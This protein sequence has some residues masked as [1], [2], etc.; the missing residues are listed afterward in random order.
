MGKTFE[1]CNE[2][3]SFNDDIIDIRREFYELS[4]Q[5]E[6]EFK[7]KYHQFGNL[8]NAFENTRQLGYNFIS[9]AVDKAIMIA[10]RYNVYSINRDTFVSYDKRNINFIQDWSNIMSNFENLYF[11]KNSLMENIISHFLQNALE[12]TIGSR[13][14][15]DA[16]H[17]AGCI[18]D[19]STD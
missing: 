16:M 12:N 14:F 19:V 18:R 17:I 13:A 3:I 5:I 2:T 1:L 15:F 9:V 10:I 4:L 6:G 8:K 11:Q 7:E